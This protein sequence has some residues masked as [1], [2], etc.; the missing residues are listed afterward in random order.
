MFFPIKKREG[1]NRREN[2][3]ERNLLDTIACSKGTE[4]AVLCEKILTT[5][6]TI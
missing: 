6:L 5:L 4:N 1:S 2:T 3:A